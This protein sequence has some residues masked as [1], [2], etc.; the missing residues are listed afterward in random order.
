VPILYPDLFTNYTTT[1]TYTQTVTGAGAGTPTWF[2]FEGTRFFVAEEERQFRVQGLK[3]LEGWGWSG[4]TNMT[5]GTS[6]NSDPSGNTVTTGSGV[7]EQIATGNFYTYNIAAA[8][9]AATNQAFY[10][11]MSDTISTW[12]IANSVSS[13]NIYLDMVVGTKSYQLMT[14]TIQKY[15]VSIG[16]LPIQLFNRDK[17]DKDIKGGT[18]PTEY[19]FGGF[20]IRLHKNSQWDD[21]GMNPYPYNNTIAPKNS[22]QIL[23]M[24]EKLVT[25]GAP[26][27]LFMRSDNDIDLG[28]I[29]KYNPGLVNPTNP[30]SMIANNAGRGY[31]MY[32]ST[33]YMFIVPDPSKLLR[34]YGQ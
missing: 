32:M 19:E 24:P 3:S 11:F 30:S 14:Q 5:T 4:N 33:E 15:Q 34:F 23:V 18:I 20:H 12:A 13:D 28:W 16:N 2:E 7:W 31:Q 8:F 17:D 26:I 6:G 21:I 25:G 22:Y 10:D 27:Q 9:A 29:F 1:W